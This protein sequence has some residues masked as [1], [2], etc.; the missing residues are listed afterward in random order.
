MFLCFETNHQIQGDL[1]HLAQYANIRM[2]GI[3][4][5]SAPLTVTGGSLIEGSLSRK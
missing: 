5:M 4:V 3:M 1:F 2:M